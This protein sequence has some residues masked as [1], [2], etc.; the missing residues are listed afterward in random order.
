MLPKGTIGKVLEREPDP[1]GHIP[2]KLTA[3]ETLVEIFI[4]KVWQR[5]LGR[6]DIGIDDDFIEA[7]GTPLLKHQM[8]L[9][10][11]KATRQQI[12]DS[13]LTARCTI[14][15]LGTLLCDGTSATELVTIAKEGDGTPLLFCHGDYATQG[16][17]VRKLAELLTCDGSILLL[18][19]Y[20]NPDPGVTIEEMAQAYLPSLLTR[21][22]NGMFRLFGYCNGAQLAWEI[23]HQL[24]GLGRQVECLILV[25]AISLNARPLP[26][27]VARLVKSALTVA[28]KRIGEWLARDVMRRV[29]DSMSDRQ[30]STPYSQAIQNY[31]PPRLKTRVVCV[32][33][34]E[35]RRRPIFSPR[36]WANLCA[37]FDCRHIRGTHRNDL[38]MLSSE[39]VPL[40]NGHLEQT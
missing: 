27:A 40:L 9:A 2:S 8:I 20:P 32:I 22:P 25:E 36:P 16:L 1:P 39:L 4:L 28:P 7:G 38:P 24:Q 6:N 17:Y 13:P 14:R 37:Q 34:E 12:P 30:F 10:V 35:S 18:H 23:A 29:W 26:R 31:V 15:G 19:P 3:P 33:S 11:E 5:L 21:H